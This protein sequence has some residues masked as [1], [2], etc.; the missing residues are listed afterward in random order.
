MSLSVKA[1]QAIPVKATK[2]QEEIDE[3]AREMAVA[4]RTEPLKGG[5]NR[6]TGGEDIGLNW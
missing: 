1:T 4:K 2:S 3:P 6:K 5:T